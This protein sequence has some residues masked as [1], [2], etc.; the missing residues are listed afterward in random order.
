M[1]MFSSHSLSYKLSSLSTD[2]SASS[3]NTLGTVQ[4]FSGFNNVISSFC[5]HK[6]T[7]KT[8]KRRGL[9]GNPGNNISLDYGFIS[10]GLLYIS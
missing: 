10:F 7:H 8:K 4:D 3:G 1:D 6:E 5:T 9:P 2:A